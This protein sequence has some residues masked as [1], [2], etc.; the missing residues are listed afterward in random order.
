LSSGFSD[1][2]RWVRYFASTDIA[3]IVVG[4]HTMLPHRSHLVSYMRIG[5]LLFIGL[6]LGSVVTAYAFERQPH[7]QMALSALNRAAAQLNAAQR[8]KGGHRAA[9][10]NLVEQAI[11]QVRAGIAFDNHH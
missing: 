10:F 9:A 1:E 3:L 2:G 4:V 6:V 11:G 5:A 7:M 8:D